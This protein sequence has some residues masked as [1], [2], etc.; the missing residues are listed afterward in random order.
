MF[1]IAPSA[2]K[3]WGLEGKDGKGLALHLSEGVWR[4]PTWAAPGRTSL[5]FVSNYLGMFIFRLSNDV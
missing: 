3:L 4:D 5:N 1:Q 2:K